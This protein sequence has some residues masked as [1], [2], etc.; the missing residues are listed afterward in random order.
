MNRNPRGF[1]LIIAMLV[2]LSLLGIAFIAAESSV[3]EDRWVGAGRFIT[4]AQYVTEGGHNLALGQVSLTPSVVA[5]AGSQI[6]EIFF[7]GTYYETP[8]DNGSSTDP[9]TFGLE[10]YVGATAGFTTQ[11]TNP[12]STNRVPGFSSDQFVFTKYSVRTTGFFQVGQPLAGMNFVRRAQGRVGGQVFVF[13]GTIG[14]N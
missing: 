3:R 13:S 12:V 9:G 2:L 6:D 4:A 7:G 10:S 14:G 11:F 1:A 5:A 8:P